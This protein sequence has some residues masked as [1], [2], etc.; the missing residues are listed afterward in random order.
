MFRLASSILEVVGSLARTLVV[1]GLVLVA[2]GLLLYAIP[3]IPFLGRLPGDIRI[4]RSTFRIYV[5]V[6]TCLL[7][8]VVL[9]AILWLFSRL[10]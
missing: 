9:S 6:T 7:I 8:S 10:R 3:S 1:A 4:E 2:L 5:P